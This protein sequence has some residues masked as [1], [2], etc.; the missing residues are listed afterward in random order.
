MHG[1]KELRQAYL[2]NW[3]AHVDA[4][5][6]IRVI[7]AAIKGVQF[8]EK[9]DRDQSD[10]Q[11]CCHRCIGHALSIRAID[12]HHR[13]RDIEINESNNKADLQGRAR[14]HMVNKSMKLRVRMQPPG[15]RTHLG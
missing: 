13:W 9:H 10:T 4:M 12:I 1:L 7:C 14:E 5:L 6:L 3:A 15:P 2:R 8:A 11:V